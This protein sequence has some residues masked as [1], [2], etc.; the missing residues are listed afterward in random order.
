MKCNKLLDR[1]VMQRTRKKLDIILRSDKNYQ[2]ALKRQNVAFEKIEELRLDKLQRVVVDRAISATNYC[3]AM[4]GVAV[5]RLGLYDGIK[6]MFE[7]R[8]VKNQ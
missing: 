8:E 7:L 6:L 4:Y 3:G 1:I 5:Y 2:D